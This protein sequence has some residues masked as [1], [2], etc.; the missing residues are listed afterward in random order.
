MIKILDF[1]ANWC[2]PCKRL[3]PIL[4]KVSQDNPD[5]S[6]EKINVETDEEN[7]SEPYG[8]LSIPT[9]IFFKDGKMVDRINGFVPEAK[10][11]NTINKWK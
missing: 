8:I 4:D 10:I 5:I 9:L 3:A 11:L 1:Y 2:Q 6:I 7:L